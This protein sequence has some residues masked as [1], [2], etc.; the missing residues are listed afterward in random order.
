MWV[1]Y[2]GTVVFWRTSIQYRTCTCT[3]TLPVRTGIS[4]RLDG[5]VIVKGLA[6]KYRFEE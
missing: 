6:S 3:C 5:A 1:Q 2:G 4:D